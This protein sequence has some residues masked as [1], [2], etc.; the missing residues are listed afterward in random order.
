MFAIRGLSAALLVLGL[1]TACSETE[2]PSLLNQPNTPLSPDV[3][4]RAGNLVGYWKME[5]NWNDSSGQN[6]HGAVAGGT[7]TFTTNAKVGTYAG[8]FDGSSYVS[9]PD[10][11][12]LGVTTSFTVM[13]WIYV[14]GPSSL[15]FWLF[16]KNAPGFGSG[17]GIAFDHNTAKIWPHLGINGG[18]HNPQSTG[19]VTYGQWNLITVTY[20]GSQIDIYLNGALDSTLSVAGTIST[21]N[22]PFYI[23]NSPGSPGEYLDGRIDNL[24][25]WNVALTPAEVQDIYVR[26]FQ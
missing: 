23:A 5:N 20:D 16:S 24:A 13:T 14:S 7:P 12:S 2:G 18:L 1:I 3:L 15:N 25:I 22:S 17:Y 10:S 9:V 26:E 19:A 8:N 4:P 11:P 6:N 21:N